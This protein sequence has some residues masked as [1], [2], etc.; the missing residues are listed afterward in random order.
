[1]S[2]AT[3]DLSHRSRSSCGHT[4]AKPD[5]AIGVGRYRRADLHKVVR[6]YFIGLVVVQ[7]IEAKLGRLPG[8][9]IG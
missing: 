5:V 9:I 7:P 8:R 1:M 3:S 6:E 2:D 4:I